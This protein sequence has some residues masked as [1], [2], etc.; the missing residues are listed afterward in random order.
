P[1]VAFTAGTT[2][3]TV[4]S[5]TTLAAGNFGQ[6]TVNSTLTLSGGTYQM[7]NLTLGNNAVVQASAASIVRVAGKVSGTTSNF[8]RIGPTGTPPAGNFRLIVAGTNDT[9]GG[10]TLGTDAKV[11]ALVVS[12]ASFSAADRFAGKGALA[13]KNVTIGNDSSLTFQTGFECNTD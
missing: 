6:V 8:V 13:A 3:L 1:I 5:P 4:S 11:T 9:N 7:Q 12:L 2:P 10:V